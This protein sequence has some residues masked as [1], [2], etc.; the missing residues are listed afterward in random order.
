[1]NPPSMMPR[2]KVEMQKKRAEERGMGSRIPGNIVW[3]TFPQM[4]A[5]V[6]H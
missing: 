1:M 5:S 4:G 2:A 3:A 6:I